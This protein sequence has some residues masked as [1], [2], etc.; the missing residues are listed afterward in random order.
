MNDITAV[1]T[2]SHKKRVL[3]YSYLLRK[4]IYKEGAQLGYSDLK[5]SEYRTPQNPRT[6]RS[7]SQKVT[8]WTTEIYCQT[9]AMSCHGKSTA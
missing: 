9:L 7:S 6:F 3:L 5:V 4:I 8:T 1:L 2:F